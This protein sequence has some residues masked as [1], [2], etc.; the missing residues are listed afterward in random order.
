MVLSNDYGL[1]YIFTFGWKKLKR[2]NRTFVQIHSEVKEI[3]KFSF[4]E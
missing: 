3:N 4:Y 1:Q 2:L